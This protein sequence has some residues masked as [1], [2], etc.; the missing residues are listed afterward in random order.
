MVDVGSGNGYNTNI[1][2]SLKNVYKIY[3]TDIL[4]H[5]PTFYEIEHMESSKAVITYIK[6]CEIL[7]MISP[8]KNYMDI[9]AINELEK[10]CEEHSEHRYLVFIGEMGASDGSDGIYKYLIDNEANKWEEITRYMI[11]ESL[12]IFGSPCEK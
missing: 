10:L 5:T 12:D 6:K 1:V 4:E 8:A 2:N 7:M 9:Y 3:A 11:D